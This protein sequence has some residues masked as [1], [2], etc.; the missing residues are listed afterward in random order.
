[1]ATLGA[2]RVKCP[3]CGEKLPPIGVRAESVKHGK[4]LDVALVPEFAPDWPEQVTATH[5]GC[6]PFDE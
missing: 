5:P 2:I 6:V 3:S 1:M 4:M